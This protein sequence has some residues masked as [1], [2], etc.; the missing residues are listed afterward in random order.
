MSSHPPDTAPVSLAPPMDAAATSPG[1]PI[2]TRGISQKPQ[3]AKHVDQPTN[4]YQVDF[5][6]PFDISL[7]SS[8]TDRAQSIADTRSAYEALLTALEGEGGLKVASRRGRGGKGK[9]E[10]WVFVSASDEKI[11]ELVEREKLL[12]EAHDL[13]SHPHNLPPSPA[14]RLRLLHA[15]LTAPPLQHGLGIT[16]GEGKWKRVKS[17]AALHDEGANKAW[18]RQWSMGGDW[19]IGLL[20]GLDS[21]H[22]GLGQH[23]P[24]PLHLYFD[25]L[26]TY[27]LS[28]LP[29]S[30]F[31][32]AFHFFSPVDSY[33][34]LFALILSLYSTIF[35]A[36]WRIRER[37]LA[38]RWGV[39]GCENVAVGRLRPEYV[40][41]LGVGTATDGQQGTAAVDVIHQ[42]DDLKRD[43][44]VAASV[45]V[46][47]LCGVGL[48]CV[49]MGIFVLEAFVS[50][51]YEGV[52]KEIVPLIPTAMFVLVVPQIMAQYQRLAKAFVHWEDHPTPVGAE[53]SL[54]GKT[55]AMN[56]I[57]A[58]LG[59]F[60]SAYVYVPFGP[61]IMQYVQQRLSGY[62][63]EK[64]QFAESAE[65]A[66]L[67]PK[68]SGE[69][70]H[71]I[72]AGRLKG[73]MYAY[74]VTNQAIGAFL[75]LG[76]PYILRF[77]DEW[78]S[79]KATLKDLSKRG[80]EEKR[81]IDGQS[82]AEVEKLFLDKVE[83]ELALPEYNIFTDYAEMVTQFGYVVIW[84]CVWPLA[85]VFAFINNY[86]EI[87]GDALKV[88]KHVRRPVGDRVETIGSWLNTLSIISWIGAVTSS[89]LIYLFR[90]STQ[91]D[92]QSPNPHIPTTGSPHM[93]RMMMTYYSYADS[94]TLRAILPTLVPVLTVAFAASHGHIILR[95]IVDAVAERLLWRGSPEEQ[96]VQKMRARTGPAARQLQTSQSHQNSAA[97]AGADGKGKGKADVTALRGGFWNG[98]EEGAREIGRIGKTE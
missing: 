14:T 85:P 16:P 12:D 75:E 45:P 63:G 72:K 98:G 34:P 60:L 50:E 11:G 41:N 97:N 89:T 77:I 20:K 18:L 52:G 35:V 61:F 84:S 62:S 64:I 38:V 79:G 13:P 53:K 4:S 15:L 26:T 44:K 48:G 92:H 76:L 67:G 19:Q 43:V 49:L 83:K 68:T 1:P 24:P 8:P 69:K 93:H 36:V 90:P 30:V 46:I 51:V 57:V 28:L 17:I 2:Q 73:Q 22:A 94:P 39:R 91:L 88:T 25:F 9:E 5:V 59:L 74:T 81:P 56:G 70:Q 71:S 65:K 86:F 80:G 58:Y 21:E 33:Q 31:G 55:F 27:T 87:R 95:W 42:G 37:K 29:L 23:Q 54:T 10:V 40:A 47:A 32:L 66:K 3:L 82:D 96:E 78:R 7:S 6:L